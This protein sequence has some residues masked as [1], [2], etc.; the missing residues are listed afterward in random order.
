[1]YFC[2]DLNRRDRSYIFHYA[3]IDHEVRLLL[4]AED[5]E[6]YRA[7]EPPVQLEEFGLFFETHFPG[8]D[9]VN[10][11]MAYRLFKDPGTGI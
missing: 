3:G 2:G 5:I 9:I 10:T 7:Q 1:M 4:I 8:Q 11:M 6:R